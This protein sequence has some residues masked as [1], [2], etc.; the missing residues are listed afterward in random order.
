MMRESFSIPLDK[1]FF[2]FSSQFARRS[3]LT[4]VTISLMAR[5]AGPASHSAR[6]A[7]VFAG[8][9]SPLLEPMSSGKS[10]RSTRSSPPFAMAFWMKRSW[11]GTSSGSP[12]RPPAACASTW[13]VAFSGCAAAAVT[14]AA[15]AGGDSSVRSATSTGSVLATAASEPAAAANAAI[16]SFVCCILTGVFAGVLLLLVLGAVSAPSSPSGTLDFPW[17]AVA[18]RL[19]RFA[20]FLEAL[21]PVEGPALSLGCFGSFGGLGRIFL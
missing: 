10:S 13:P 5:P 15:A 11:R 16:E 7:T 4:R 14:S 17:A 9:A 19:D 6:M 20:D 18:V 3:S 2:F 8:M 1:Y 21:A 12:S